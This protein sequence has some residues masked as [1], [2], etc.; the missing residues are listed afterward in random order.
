VERSR[1]I[2]ETRERMEAAKNE[3][4]MKVHA[5]YEN[6]RNEKISQLN[7]FLREL[8]EDPNSEIVQFRLAAGK[9][10]EMIDKFA[11][12]AQRI[13]KLQIENKSLRDGTYM[14]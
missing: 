14:S 11:L 12:F 8:N 3:L 10:I 5:E 2:A 4:L 7:S 13:H 1:A 6:E 9:E